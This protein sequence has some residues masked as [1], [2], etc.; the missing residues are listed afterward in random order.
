LNEGLQVRIVK[1]RARMYGCW[2][3][4]C[5]GQLLTQTEQQTKNRRSGGET[6]AARRAGG[7]SGSHN[8][9]RIQRNERRKLAPPSLP[10]AGPGTL[11]TLASVTYLPITT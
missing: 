4:M 8:S 2:D 1:E 9:G 3:L 11:H 5:R 6:V 10:D 7:K